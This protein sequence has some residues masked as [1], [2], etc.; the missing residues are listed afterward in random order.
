GIWFKADSAYIRSLSSEHRDQIS[1]KAAAWMP[2]LK[3]DSR[4]ICEKGECR[5]SK[6]W[7]F[8]VAS[9]A[10]VQGSPSMKVIRDLG[11]LLLAA[12]LILT[13]LIPLLNL[14]FSGL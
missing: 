6:S 4:I 2:K 9:P 5:V 7:S 8:S 1:R 10:R 11:M 13:G 3:R 14:S 12:W